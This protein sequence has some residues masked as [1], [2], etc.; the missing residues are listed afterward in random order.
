M[1]GKMT[2]TPALSLAQYQ[3]LTEFGETRRMKRDTNVE[4]KDPDRDPIRNAVGLTTGREGAY[5]V[6]GDDSR[7]LVTNS[8]QPPDGQPGLYCPLRPSKDGTSILVGRNEREDDWSAGEWLKYI[9]EHFLAVWGIDLNGRWWYVDPEGSGVIVAQKGEVRVSEAGL[10]YTD[11][12]TNEVA[13]VDDDENEDD[14][15]D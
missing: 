15:D 5:I 3:Y 7:R 1:N 13:F 8:N 12:F 2:L 11:P 9:A 14:D 6:H 4:V 10:A